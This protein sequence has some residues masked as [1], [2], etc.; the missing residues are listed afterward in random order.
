M[1]APFRLAIIGSRGIPAAYGGFETFAEQ[2]G[3]RLAAIGWSV[4]VYGR[5]HTVPEGMTEYLGCRIVAVPTIRSKHLDTVVA[6]A[7]QVGH[8]LVSDYDAVLAVNAANAPFLLP[9]KILRIRTVLNV[10][11]IERMRAKWGIAGRAW[12][13]LGEWFATR[14]P[15]V[16]VADAEVIA[17]YYRRRHGIESTVIPYGADLPWPSG[18]DTLERYGL[19]PRGYLLYVSRFEPEN[20]PH[21][22]VEE[23]GRFREGAKSPPPLVMVG[24]APY[25]KEWI[26]SWKTKAPAGAVFPGAVYGEGYRE[27]LS[28]CWAYVQATEVGGTHPALVEAM[29]YGCRIFWNDTPENREVA[30]GCGV[31]FRAREPGSLAAAIA[32]SLDDAA[33]WA[34]YRSNA[35][36]RARE[37]YSWNAVAEAYR[38]LLAPADGR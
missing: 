14:M 29:G 37:R 33:L 24:D 11:G 6:T 8:A 25:Q 10:D 30:D 35:E 19:P 12:Y 4:T 31:P 1:S 2:L 16:V 20:N 17:D 36:R 9:L 18:T 32:G 22:V 3:A 13:R 27:L 15:D 38:A 23:Y 21:R 28:N 5:R 7:L 34:V 26:A